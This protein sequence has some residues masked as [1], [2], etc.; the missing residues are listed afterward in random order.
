MVEAGNEA[1]EMKIKTTLNSKVLVSVYGQDDLQEGP[2]DEFREL[3]KEETRDE[4]DVGLLSNSNNKS[5]SN[6]NHNHNH[7]DNEPMILS[8]RK[9]RA[10]T[11]EHRNEQN[12]NEEDKQKQ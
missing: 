12:Q 4:D 1:V 5:N 3:M 6:H 2:D 9:S 11:T 7:N 8:P 10:Q